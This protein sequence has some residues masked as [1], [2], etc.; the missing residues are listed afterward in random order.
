MKALHG[1]KG[2]ARL[3]YVDDFLNKGQFPAIHEQ[4]AQ[5]LALLNPTLRSHGALDLGACHG[6]LTIRAARLFATVVGIEPDQRSVEVFNRHLARLQQNAMMFLLKLDVL[7]PSHQQQLLHLIQQW[8]IKTIIARRAFPETLASTYGDKGTF[9]KACEAGQA[10]S[11]ICVEG[12]VQCI[13]LEGRVASEKRHSHPLW[14]A[15][16]EVQALGTPWCVVKN[17]HD[18]R[19]LMR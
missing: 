19:V 12:G 7:E 5:E 4:I 6:L 15:D 17:H 2:Y 8:S 1:G 18:I 9:A 14:N 3:D 10:F 13:V 11:H 16:L